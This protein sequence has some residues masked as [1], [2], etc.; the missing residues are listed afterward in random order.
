[1]L[2]HFIDSMRDFFVLFAD[3]IADCTFD[4]LSFFLY[5]Y[6]K[7]AAC[8]I[9]LTQILISRVN[10]VDEDNIEKIWKKIHENHESCKIIA[11]REFYF[12]QQIAVVNILILL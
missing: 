1:M 5:W 2:L 8:N 11:F 9:I 4:F 3:F 12:L 10:D 7:Q 6:F